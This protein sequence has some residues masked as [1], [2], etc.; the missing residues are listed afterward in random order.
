MGFIYLMLTITSLLA[1][2]FMGSQGASVQ[3]DLVAITTYTTTILTTPMTIW[4]IGTQF[5]MI[6][7][8]PHKQLA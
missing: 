5:M 3:G 1:T 6:F 7:G 4:P 8:I 2:Q